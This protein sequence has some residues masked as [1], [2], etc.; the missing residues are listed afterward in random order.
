M[1]IPCILLPSPYRGS[2]E[3]GAIA[4]TLYLAFTPFSF[5]QRWEPRRRLRLLLQRDRS[6]RGYRLSC[7]HSLLVACAP[8][9]TE[10]RSRRT[11]YGRSSASTYL[12]LTFL[13]G[14]SA[15]KSSGRLK[16]PRATWCGAPPRK[17]RRRRRAD[18]GASRILVIRFAPLS[19]R[20]CRYRCKVGDCSTCY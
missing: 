2:K 8:T 19:W 18:I 10:R 11:W 15:P 3:I 4:D 1:R 20:R 17:P 9:P 7:F 5:T 12:I 14:G 6:D 16:S 13:L